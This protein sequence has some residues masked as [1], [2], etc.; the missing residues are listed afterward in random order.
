LRILHENTINQQPLQQRNPDHTINFG[1]L[2]KAAHNVPSFQAL[3]TLRAACKVH[4]GVHPSVVGRPVNAKAAAAGLARN[5]RIC[6]EI[7][8]NIW[9]IIGVGGG[10]G[11][12]VS[13]GIVFNRFGASSTTVCRRCSPES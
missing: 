10:T 5:L 8:A 4:L 9:E 1:I 12:G 6:I 7:V 11:A 3:E 13:T 2:L